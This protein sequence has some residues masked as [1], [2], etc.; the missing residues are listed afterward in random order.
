MNQAKKH[1]KVVDGKKICSLCLV[2]KPVSEFFKDS[3]SGKP[4]NRCKK[5]HTSLNKKSKVEK[6]TT[7]PK[8]K[9][10]V[11]FWKQG[12]YGVNPITMQLSN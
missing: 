6:V 4:R 11:P 8:P 5:C 1:F 7:P 9:R 2:D 12:L 10:K 3:R